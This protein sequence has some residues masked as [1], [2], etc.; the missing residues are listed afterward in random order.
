ME[1]ELVQVAP[2]GA[3][4]LVECRQEKPDGVQISRGELPRPFQV[5]PLVSLAEDP[6]TWV[7]ASDAS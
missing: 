5:R 4:S 1:K 3:Q 6:K 7:N 2:D